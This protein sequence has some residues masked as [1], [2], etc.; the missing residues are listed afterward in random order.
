MEQPDSLFDNDDVQ[1]NGLMKLKDAVEQYNDITDDEYFTVESIAWKLLI[2]DDNIEQLSSAIKTMSDVPDTEGN[3][4]TFAFEIYMNLFCELVFN[5]MKI[6]FSSD[7]QNNDSEFY[8]DYEKNNLEDI[9]SI[10]KNKYAKLHLLLCVNHIDINFNNSVNNYI[11]THYHD[12]YSRILLVDNKYDKKMMEKYGSCKED[13]KFYMMLG[14]QRF[15]YVIK[16]DYNIRDVYSI[17][18][19]NKKIYKIYFNFV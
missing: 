13:N 2:D 18:V 15:N 5:M 6:Q 10:L 4:L 14:S 19:A 9:V 3:P 11:D 7:P 17:I 12:R 16:K 8:P 1:E